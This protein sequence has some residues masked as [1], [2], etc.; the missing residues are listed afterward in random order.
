MAWKKEFEAKHK[1]EK[2]KGKKETEAKVTGKE[3]FLGKP[4][5]EDE[6]DSDDEEEDSSSED[7]LPE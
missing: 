5:I 3:W 7:D 1:V 2:D 4:D 6:P